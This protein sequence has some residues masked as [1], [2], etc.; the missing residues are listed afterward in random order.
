MS[1]KTMTSILTVASMAALMLAAA[2]PASAGA[3]G[4]YYCG[5]GAAI[6]GVTESAG[7]VTYNAA[8]GHCGVLGL[9]VNYVHMGG[10]SWTSWK[11]S[12]YGA[13]NVRMSTKNAVRS[14]H[15]SSLGSLTFYSYK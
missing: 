1:R 14:M 9:R 6:I 15:S 7:Q 10:D 13:D 5:A 12:A 11:Y 2:T 4:P 3:A 8:P